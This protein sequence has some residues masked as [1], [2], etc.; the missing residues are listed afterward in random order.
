MYPHI[1]NQDLLPIHL[2]ASHGL[3][4]VIEVL[5]KVD[6]DSL[7]QSILEEKRNV[8][9]V[10]YCDYRALLHTKSTMFYPKMDLFML[11][12]VFS[13]SFQDA[14]SFSLL[15]LALIRDHLDCACW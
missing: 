8:R 13:F 6:A 9:K 3:I 14:D 15:Y 10:H 11:L 2:A 1:Y 7:Q 12:E 5:L 4:S